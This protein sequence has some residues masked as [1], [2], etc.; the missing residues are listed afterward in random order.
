MKQAQTSP[1][2]RRGR[3]AAWTCAVLVS[4]WMHGA[5]GAV[6]VYSFGIAAETGQTVIDGRTLSNIEL[7]QISLNNAGQIAFSARFSGLSGRAVTTLD[8]IVAKSGDIFSGITLNEAFTSNMNEGGRVTFQ[9]LFAGPAGDNYGMFDEGGLVARKNT[10]IDAVSM[11]AVFGPSHIDN[12][13]QVYFT[14]NT[15][16]I[17]GGPSVMSSTARI[18]HF[19]DVIDGKRW[20]GATTNRPHVSGNGTVAIAGGFRGTAANPGNGSGIFALGATTGLIAEAGDVF[21]GESWS[22]RASKIALNDDGFFAWFGNIQGGGNALF[23]TDGLIA[24]NGDT[25]GG[26]QILILNPNSTG[27]GP[28]TNNS[29]QLVSPATISGGSA[30]LSNTGLSVG[31]GDTIAG[32]TLSTIVTHPVINDLGQVAFIGNFTGGTGIFLASPVTGGPIVNPGFE[33]PGLADWTVEGPGTAADVEFPA[34]S[35][36]TV[37]QLTAGSP[38][39]LSQVVDTPNVPFTLAR[40]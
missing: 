40:V 31:T 22:G 24:R 2:A 10:L 21:G 36:N 8:R 30:I 4:I 39:T 23:S 34:S 26:K 1:W 20:S 9:G 3:S 37:A 11:D 32:K 18:L 6:T 17:F 35:G 16:G 12:A 25:V 19:D 7:Q 38:V 28:D 13:G 27:F 5:A 29:R 15:S 14:A 33:D